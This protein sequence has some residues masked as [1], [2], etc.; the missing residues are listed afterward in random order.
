MIIINIVLL[1]GHLAGGVVSAYYAAEWGVGNIT[2][3][4]LSS[5]AVSQTCHSVI[6]R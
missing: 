2:G 5:A 3:N 6:E 1:L 4:S